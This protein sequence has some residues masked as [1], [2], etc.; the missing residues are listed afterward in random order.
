MR[1]RRRSIRKV[2][3]T[4]K[5]LKSIGDKREAKGKSEIAWKRR[6]PCFFFIF[7]TSHFLGCPILHFFRQTVVTCNRF[8][9]NSTR[10]IFILV[11]LFCVKYFI[12][13]KKLC[14]IVENCVFKQKKLMISLTTFT[15]LS[16]LMVDLELTKCK[17]KQVVS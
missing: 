10:I 14:A 7:K 16:Y 17:S 11:E 5:W 6:F 9:S 2:E 3:L 8:G 13:V 1:E 4:K 12:N 15:K